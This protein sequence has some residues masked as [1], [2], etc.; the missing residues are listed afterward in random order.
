MAI[1]ILT[2]CEVISHLVIFA[3]SWWLVMLS[4]FSCACWPCVSL[5]RKNVYS[6]ILPIFNGVVCFLI[7]SCMSCLYML[8]I[9]PLSVIS[10]ANILSCLVEIILV[11]SM[12]PFVVQNVLRLFRSH[13]FIFAFVSFAWRDSSKQILVGLMSKTVLL[14]FFL[15]VLEFLVLHLGFFKIYF[16][17]IFV[18]GVIKCSNFILCH[19]AVQFFMHHLLKR[20]S[21]LHC[22]ALPPLL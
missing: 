8:H 22:I 20:L 10:F 5:L 13:L 11:L 12:I 4:I 7:L 19:I 6:V 2:R 9:N 16:E 17:F 15:E 1:G 18:D 14:M 21:F 3:F